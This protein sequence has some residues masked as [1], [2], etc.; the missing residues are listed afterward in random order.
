M[1]QRNGTT[2][3]L[4]KGIVGRSLTVA[5]QDAPLLRAANFQPPNCLTTSGTYQT[6]A[7]AYSHYIRALPILDSPEYPALT[8]NQA[9]SKPHSI[10]RISLTAIQPVQHNPQPALQPALHHYQPSISLEVWHYSSLAPSPWLV[11]SLVC[12]VRCCPTLHCGFEDSIV[13]LNLSSAKA[14]FVHF[15]AK[16]A[17]ASQENLFLALQRTDTTVGDL[18]C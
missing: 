15:E 13:H 3:F 8:S 4:V 7:S 14:L 10:S 11:L 5:L 9:P 1:W 2:T 18:C 17:C 6:A 12:S 16:S